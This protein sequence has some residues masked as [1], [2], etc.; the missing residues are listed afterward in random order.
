VGLDGRLVLATLP[1]AAA[2][3]A[4][5]RQ[6]PV[7]DPMVRWWRDFYAAA[8]QRVGEYVADIDAEIRGESR[9]EVERPP[10]W[11]EE[12]HPA[13]D[14]VIQ[15]THY[16]W[17]QELAQP[18]EYVQGWVV[19]LA[20]WRLGWHLA[21]ERAAGK[22]GPQYDAAM[23]ARAAQALLG[24]TDDDAHTAWRDP[25]LFE[26]RWQVFH[27]D[28]TDTL[29]VAGLHQAELRLLDARDHDQEDT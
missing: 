23:E 22:T 25:P 2:S 13:L 28:D 9:L 8:P 27:T 17:S 15:A 1:L 20:W 14:D 19:R 21:R 29:T 4:R 18:L 26:Q 24:W 10:H 5:R 12:H 11:L 7:E 16:A 3:L 6:P